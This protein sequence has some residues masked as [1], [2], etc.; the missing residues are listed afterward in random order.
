[1]FEDGWGHSVAGYVTDYVILVTCFVLLFMSKS[2]VGFES[3]DGKQLVAFLLLTGLAFGFGG[4]AH[5]LIDSYYASGELM[6]KAWGD[7]NSSWMYPWLLAMVIGGLSG[8][9][10]P[11]VAFS[12]TKL[13]PWMGVIA[14]VLGALVAGYEF[15]IFVFT[16]EGINITGTYQGYYA[17]VGTFIA[18]IT[19]LV[20]IL[21]QWAAGHGFYS[22]T[23]H[24]FMGTVLLM[25]GY[26]VLVTLP[27][28]C[29]KP[30]AERVGCPYPASFNQNAVFHSIIVVGVIVFVTGCWGFGDKDY[31]AVP[32]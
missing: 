12:F 2:K 16:A 7:A 29:S 32:K 27:P 19:F 21:R 31:E 17:M 6:G 14:Y 3:S 20:S 30:G 24:C 1:L 4:V 25:C 5:H 26:L 8:G 9:G 15:Y 18:L 13:P 22:A 23:P 11:S 10:P 28:G